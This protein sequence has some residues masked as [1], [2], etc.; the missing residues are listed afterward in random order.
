VKIQPHT[1]QIV[2]LRVT[3]INNQSICLI[4]P[5]YNR[6]GPSFCIPRTILSAKRYH[7]YQIWYP[8]NEPIYLAPKTLIGQVTQMRDILS[9][10]QNNNPTDTNET[11]LKQTDIKQTETYDTHEKKR[12][13]GKNR[14]VELKKQESGQ[15]KE[16]EHFTHIIRVL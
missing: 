13:G 10:A 6:A 12:Q 15:K 8:T 14:Q 4:E 5:I 7:C 16:T 1:Q 9:I 2:D 11:D 3:R